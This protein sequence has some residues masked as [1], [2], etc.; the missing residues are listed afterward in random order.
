LRDVGE[1]GSYLPL[2]ALASE[3]LVRVSVEALH[4]PATV[5]VA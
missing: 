2:D 1:L 4:Q 3:A 5:F